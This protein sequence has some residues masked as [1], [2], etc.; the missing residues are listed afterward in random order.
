MVGGGEQNGQLHWR[1]VL[2][3]VHHQVIV[4]DGLLGPCSGPR[5]S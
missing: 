1:E 5:W 4:G 3:L 2:H